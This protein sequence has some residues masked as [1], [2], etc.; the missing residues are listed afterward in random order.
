MQLLEKSNLLGYVIAVDDDSETV[1]YYYTGGSYSNELLSA[2]ETYFDGWAI[3]LTNKPTRAKALCNNHKIA[4][5]LDLYS[6]ET[7]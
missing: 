2:L 6:A 5:I 7:I 4:E 1:L 3:I